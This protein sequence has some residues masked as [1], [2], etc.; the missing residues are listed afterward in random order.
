GTFVRA[1][2]ALAAAAT[3]V[4]V[5]ATVSPAARSLAARRGPSPVMPA[6]FNPRIRPVTAVMRPATAVRTPGRVRQNP[7]VSES[8]IDATPGPGVTL[9]LLH[10]AAVQPCCSSMCALLACRLSDG[11]QT[12]R[13]VDDTAITAAFAD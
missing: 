8:P 11:R 6:W 1:V 13:D 12:R 5:V 4:G 2:S 10:A 3:V 9:V 7:R